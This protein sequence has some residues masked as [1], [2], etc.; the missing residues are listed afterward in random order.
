MN[1]SYSIEPRIGFNYKVGERN[2]LSF[3]YGLHSQTLPLMVYFFENYDTSLKIYYQT[4]KN[5]GLM[6]AHHFIA[7][8]DFN[9]LKNFRLKTELYYQYLFN[10]P[11]KGNDSTSYSAINMGGDYGF[12]NVDSLINKGTGYNYG[13]ELTLEKF[14]SNHYYFLITSSLFQSEYKGSD[15]I[16]RNTKF[17]GHFVLNSLF[18]Y[19]LKY[20]K[21][22]IRRFRLI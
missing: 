12:P 21:I 2:Q 14:F 7:G 15:N 5:L 8:Y 4:N 18:G 10:I 16:L 1:G 22:K 20:G 6:K 3:G 11:V 13:I 19:E 9:F 17:N